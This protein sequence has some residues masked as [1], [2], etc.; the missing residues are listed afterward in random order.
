MPVIDYVINTFR[1]WAGL[2]QSEQ[3]LIRMADELAKRA[4]RFAASKIAMAE[5]QR[6]TATKL[7]E[8]ALDADAAAARATTL[9]AGVTI[10]ADDA[11]SAA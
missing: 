4:R 1:F 11:D 2:R 7:M 8:K 9:A 6:V 3:R 10:A 5:A